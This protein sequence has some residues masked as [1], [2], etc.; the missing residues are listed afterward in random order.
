[1]TEGE[2]IYAPKKIRLKIFPLNWD[3][4]LPAGRANSLRSITL[5]TCAH[6]NVTSQ[7]IIYPNPNPNQKNITFKTQNPNPNTKAA[8]G[9]RIR[10][11]VSRFGSVPNSV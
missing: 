6:T 1:M 11:R 7:T 2:K 4:I 8:D 10:V 3:L 9:F 5:C